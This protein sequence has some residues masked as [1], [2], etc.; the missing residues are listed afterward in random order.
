[1]PMGFKNFIKIVMKFT[2]KSDILLVEHRHYRYVTY[3]YVVHRHYRYVTYCYVVHRH[4]RYVMYCYVVHHQYRYVTD[5]IYNL[6]YKS[7]CVKLDVIIFFKEL[8]I[9]HVNI[10]LTLQ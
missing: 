4:Y 6:K 3:C 2:L 10:K 5:I 9:L 8:N 1:M 7:P